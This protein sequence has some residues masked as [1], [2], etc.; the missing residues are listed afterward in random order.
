[1][2]RAE[3]GEQ[4]DWVLIALASMIGQIG[5]PGVGCD[6]IL[7]ENKVV[8]ILDQACSTGGILNKL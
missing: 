8:T 3:S 5:L 4:A 1:M 7:K 2:Q 6:D